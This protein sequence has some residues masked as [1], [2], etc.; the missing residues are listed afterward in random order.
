MYAINVSPDPVIDWS[1]EA[2]RTIVPSSAGP[3]NYGNKFPGEAAVYMGIVHVAIYDA[4]VAIE[5]G[6]EPYAITLIAPPNT[7]SAAA[8]ATAAHH[9]LIGLQPPL[10]LTPAQQA[11]LDGDYA[12]YLAAI[13]DGAAKTNGVA[14]GEQ[15]AAAVVAL[16]A[17]DGREQNPT[18]A[19]LNPPPPALASGSQTPET[20]S[21][22]CLGLRLPGIRPLALESASQFRPDGPNALTSE[23]YAEDFNQ[24]KELGRFDSTV[25]TPEQTTQALF[26]TDHDIKQWND[27]MLAPRHRPRA[28]PR[29]DGPDAGDGACLRERRDDCLLRGQ[30]PLL[31]LA[32]L[33][34]HPVGRC[35]RE[36]GHCGRSDVAAAAH[37]TEL[38][39]V[40]VGARL[41]QHRSGRGAP[42]ILRHRQGALLPRQRG[43]RHLAE[44]R[45]L[46]RRGQR[47]ESGAGP[48]RLPL[49]QLRL[50]RVAPRRQEGRPL[51]R[52]TLLPASPRPPTINIIS[53]PVRKSK[54]ANN[55]PASTKKGTIMNSLPQ[56]KKI[57]ILSSVI[58]Q[59]LVALTMAMF[60]PAVLGEG[61]QHREGPPDVTVAGS[62]GRMFRNLPPF[63][64]PTNAVRDA[65]M[66]LG[67]LGGVLD[68]DDDLAAGPVALIT[69]PN[70]QLINRNNPTHT[71]GVT[72]FGQFLDHDMTFDLTSRLGFPTQPVRS[73]NART[74]FFDLDSVYA[75]GPG[76]NPELFDPIDSIK[77]RVESGGQYRR[78]ATGSDEQRSDH[79]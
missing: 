31:V 76:G 71:A 10:G 17:N 78:S 16:R 51:R 45:P 57:P 67:S 24:V 75:N 52:Q 74:P 29:A 60:L 32:S 8:I 5:G 43:H 15:V 1:N 9:T 65:L 3:E 49:F 2:R 53:K 18:L 59:A 20:P 50:G 37:D 73:P 70:L 72:F 25:R 62:F 66:E 22:R 68:A 44:L 56:F 33:P 64:P 58:A 21:H 30:V 54:H 47:R 13:P 36:P 12:N 40:S 48:G 27:S 69:D 4:A 46:S 11:I 35:R 42:G 6:Y 79:R 7:S 61:T 77:F 28:R 26:W 19:D 41:P 14:V 39:R 63:A 34:G 38:S 23:D 55:N